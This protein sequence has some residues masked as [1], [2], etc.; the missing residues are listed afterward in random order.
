MKKPRFTERRSIAILNEADAGVALQG[1][2]ASTGSIRR[3]TTDGR[4]YGGATLSQLK[5]LKA[6][7]GELGQ[8]KRRCAELAHEDYALKDLIE[9]SSRAVADSQP[10]IWKKYKVLRRVG[11]TWNTS[12]CVRCIAR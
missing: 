7:E 12:V 3:R 8:Y 5:R 2:W 9:P 11:R 6:F 10:R 4:Q 1:L